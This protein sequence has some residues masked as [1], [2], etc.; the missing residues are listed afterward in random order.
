MF[1]SKAIFSLSHLFLFLIVITGPSYSFM[2]SDD[3]SRGVIKLY[4][5]VAEIVNLGQNRKEIL[6]RAKFQYSDQNI[7]TDEA[8]A[9]TGI[10]SG[11][12]FEKLGVSVYF[13]NNIASLISIQQPFSGI[14]QGKN[15]AV[16]DVKKPLDKKWEDFIS[17]RLGQPE[18]TRTN[19]SSL[20]GDVFYYSW[21]E[22]QFSITGIRKLLLYRNPAI[23]KFRQSKFETNDDPIY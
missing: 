17:E 22:V 1:H 10:S 8:L 19:T 9:K 3:T 5:G 11:I 7:P 21:G 2:Q 20:R 15:L 14:I 4:M 12:T 23:R 18:V 13:I 16:F 6:E